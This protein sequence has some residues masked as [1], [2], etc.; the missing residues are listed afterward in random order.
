MRRRLGDR[1]SVTAEFAVALPAIVL[2][3]VLCVGALSSAGRQV[4]LQDATADAARLI[5]RGDEEGRALGLVATVAPGARAS[6]ARDGDTVC[7]TGS[8]PAAALLAGVRLAATSC[9]LDGGR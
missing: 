3:L 2:L 1:G 6:V 8:A 9:A 7:V 4:R 5:A